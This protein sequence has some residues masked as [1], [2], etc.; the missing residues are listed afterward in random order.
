MWCTI[1]QLT[2]HKVVCFEARIY[3]GKERRHTHAAMSEAGARTWL[4]QQGIP[5]HKQPRFLTVQRG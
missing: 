2:K 3:C 4:A 1:V 5:F